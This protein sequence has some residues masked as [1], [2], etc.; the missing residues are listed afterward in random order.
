MDFKFTEEQNLLR[1]SIAEVMKKDITIDYVRECD[2]K[3]EYPYRFYEKAVELGWVALA[4]P[5]E[6][7]GLGGDAIELA[8]LGEETSRYG[9]DLAEAIGLTMFNGRSIVRH[10]TQEQKQ[11]YIPKAING[12]IRFC[13]SI[14]E[15][16]AGSDTSSL[17][18]EAV[19]KPGE[20]VINGHKVFCSGAH[21]RNSII[22][23]FARTDNA[24]KKDQGLSVFL[25]PT[26]TNGILI[27]RIQTLGWRILGN[28]D[29]FLENVNVPEKNLLGAL[30]NG[31]EV[32]TSGID[33]ERLYGASSYVGN[34]QT[35]LETSLQHAKQRVQFGQPIGSFQ[36]I[37]H[38]LCDMQTELEAGRLLVY[39][40]AWNMM[41]EKPSLKEVSMAKLYTSETFVR[42]AAMGIQIMGGYGFCDD[43]MQ[44]YFRASRVATIVAGTSQ[45]QRKIIA[46]S[47]GLK[48]Q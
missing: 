28:N 18:T 40:A 21:A 10:G 35:I 6:Y 7:G 17:K 22:K 4:F 37:S 48:V 25:I 3:G 15:P 20:Y 23:L 26:D 2:E 24:L 9:T 30:N 39:R 31:A 27:R 46:T 45:I 8:I 14:T 1:D 32:L 38:M 42:H 43:D 36:A 12:E 44:R 5:E 47:M 11:Y 34:T 33:L 19:K 41:Q 16:G 29:L 13:I